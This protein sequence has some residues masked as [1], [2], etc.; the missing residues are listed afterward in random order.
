MLGGHFG[1]DG[2]VLAEL[3]PWGHFIVVC[4]VLEQLLLGGY[5]G[6]Y[7]DVLAASPQEG[8]HEAMTHT[9]IM[10]FPSGRLHCAS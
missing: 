4:D 9:G 3:L 6:V 7:G 5:L 10:F 2:E 1:V 8:L